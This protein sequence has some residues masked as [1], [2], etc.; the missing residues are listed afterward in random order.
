MR[1]SGEAAALLQARAGLGKVCGV[2]PTHSPG[3]VIHLPGP[4]ATV[5]G[6]WPLCHVSRSTGSAGQGPDARDVGV[7]QKGQKRNFF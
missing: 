5:P 6:V 3:G 2:G 7:T 1:E 4:D